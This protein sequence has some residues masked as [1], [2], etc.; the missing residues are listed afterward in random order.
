M[1]SISEVQ[2]VVDSQHKAPQP[3]ELDQWQSPN[4]HNKNKIK[5]LL[6]PSVLKHLQTCEADSSNERFHWTL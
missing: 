2:M 3:Q 5:H 1:S 6:F 4:E